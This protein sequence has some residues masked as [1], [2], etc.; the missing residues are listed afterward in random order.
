[1]RSPRLGHRPLRHHIKK[2]GQHLL[3]HFIPHERNN[4]HPHFLRHRVLVG[5]SL[6]LILVKVAVVV[7]PIA[8]PSSSL[9]SSAITP[10]NIIDLTNQ[11]RANLGLSAL[12]IN[13]L[14]MQAAQNK[15]N[16]MAQN[17]YFSHTSPAGVTP[18][19]WII[20]AGY[21]YRYAGENLAVH[22]SQ[23]EE[24][25]AGWLA[26]PTHRANIASDKY[27][28]IGL[29]VAEGEYQGTVG[30]FVVQMFGLS[31]ADVEAMP[32]TPVVLTEATPAPVVV[33][34][35]LAPE[36][37][38]SES[39]LAKEQ[40]KLTP[41]SPIVKQPVNL[42]NKKVIPAEKIALNKPTSTALNSAP[43]AVVAIAPFI[44]DDSVV[45][46]PLNQGYEISA[47]VTGA[48]SVTAQIGG[49]T[50]ALALLPDKELWQGR[51]NYNTATA[52]SAGEQLSLLAVGPTGQTS[53]KEVAWLAPRSS[54]QQFFNYNQPEDK[55]ARFFSFLNIG[56]L[57]DD[58]R[59][60]YLY[61]IIFLTAALLLNVFIK[62]KIQKLPVIG[63]AAL[64]LALA[65]FL[66]LV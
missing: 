32:K 12:Q 13:N 43:V 14:L 1:M 27:K 45:I 8:L 59:Q 25:L 18:W 60:F 4:H 49:Q 55:V 58:V 16:D 17:K 5:Y 39:A 54:P 64:V 37:A 56:N 42:E 36:V 9:Y 19:S 65:V 28:E 23:A 57:N 48:Q 62:Q 31:L 21:T 61:F 20:G 26:S 38:G 50:F 30:T 7:L 15:A 33:S 52:G 63:H 44:Y 34:E 46:S 66:A 41:A 29:G 22:F 53:I 51:V 2:V 11:T 10:Q 6:I 40:V 35:K 3:D 47:K 24:T